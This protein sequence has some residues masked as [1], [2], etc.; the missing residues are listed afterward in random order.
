VRNA[1]VALSPFFPTPILLSTSPTKLVEY[2]SLGL[3]VIANDHP[4]QRLVLRQSRGGICVPWGSRHFARAVAWLARLN[5][6]QR[7]K[8]G[9]RGRQWVKENR[10]YERI[11]TMLEEKYLALLSSAADV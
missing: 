4:E 7:R 11:A 6:E 10:S 2:L 9:A 5:S 1:D 3:P 8:I